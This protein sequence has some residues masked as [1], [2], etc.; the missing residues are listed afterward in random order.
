MVALRARSESFS[1]TC[2]SPWTLSSW[3]G[4][5][6]APRRTSRA[7]VDGT[8]AGPEPRRR[9]PRVPDLSS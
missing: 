2:G 9:I 5:E 1:G 3:A 4:A 6:G 8:A 7:G